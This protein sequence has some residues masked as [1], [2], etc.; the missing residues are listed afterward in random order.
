[1]FPIL[2]QIA[3]IGC[4]TEPAPAADDAL[5]VTR[6]RLDAAMRAK[7]GR[8]LVIRHVDAGSCNGCELEIHALGNPYYNLEALGIKFNIEMLWLPD[9][10]F[11]Q[12]GKHFRIRFGDLKQGDNPSG[13]IAAYVRHLFSFSVQL[14]GSA[15]GDFQSSELG[16]HWQPHFRQ[17]QVS[18]I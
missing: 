3:R 9:E 13:S 4:I 8:A 17:R 12:G 2:R 16:I 7:L 5:R 10:M 18:S 11:S 6:Q 14:P 15:Q 1:M